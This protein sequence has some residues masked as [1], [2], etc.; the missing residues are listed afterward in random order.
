LIDI[1]LLSKKNLLFIFVAKFFNVGVAFALEAENAIPV[2]DIPLS[3]KKKRGKHEFKPIVEDSI[4]PRAVV[5][6]PLNALKNG[7]SKYF[8][9]PGDG[10]LQ[11]PWEADKMIKKSFW[12]CSQNQRKRMPLLFNCNGF[13]KYATS[14]SC[15]KTEESTFKRDAKSS[16]FGKRSLSHQDIMSTQEDKIIATSEFSP[17]R[18]FSPMSDM[19]QLRADKDVGDKNSD[20]SFSS[21][22]EIEGDRLQ[23]SVRRGARFPV[24]S[25][26]LSNGNQIY[27]PYL[28][29][30]SPVTSHSL[31]HRRFL[32]AMEFRISNG[33]AAD[34]N[35][36]I[37]KFFQYPILRSDMQAFKAANPGCIFNDFVRWY[38]SPAEPLETLNNQDNGDITAM[39]GN[40][41]VFDEEQLFENA[42]RRHFSRGPKHSD[43]SIESKLSAD[44]VMELESFW[45]Q[46]WEDAK[47]VPAFEQ[48]LKLFDAVQEVEKVIHSLENLSPIQLMNYVLEINFTTAYELLYVR[49]GDALKVKFIEMML[50]RLAEKT[51]TALLQLKEDSFFFTLGLEHP[52]SSSYLTGEKILLPITLKTCESLCNAI[53]EVELILSRASSLLHKFP[54][55]YDLVHHLLTLGAGEE[56]QLT[57]ND[58]EGQLS[59]FQSI[60]EGILGLLRDPS[61]MLEESSSNSEEAVNLLD[62][63]LPLPVSREFVLCNSN[64]SQPCRLLAQIRGGPNEAEDHVC[65][66][67]MSRCFQ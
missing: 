41:C 67:A 3:T 66:L 38:G 34:A 23:K 18:S 49:A 31:L 51:R 28:Q 60:Q 14:T 16:Q 57:M 21:E 63:T 30:K 45:K 62:A 8:R 10:E 22:M 35:I 6:T 32:A 20:E 13:R 65:I 25:L 1:I 36:K 9:S 19:S 53:G 64:D 4:I 61:E 47:P 37:R 48:D 55:Q 40:I 44:S 54:D 56:F 58:R 5:L 2:Q 43:N 39:E 52:R 46:I 26:F 27:E 33:D 12:C 50:S 17:T 29:N 42:L 59:T 24:V 7:E 15:A 11:Y